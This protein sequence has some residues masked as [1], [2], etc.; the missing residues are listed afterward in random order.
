M[1]ALLLLERTVGNRDSLTNANGT[2]VGYAYDELNRLTSVTNYSPDDSVLS[3]FTYV[4]NNAGIRTVVTEADASTGLSTS[5]SRVNYIYDDCYKLTS[6]TRSGVHPY[7]ISY[8][9]DNIGNRLTRTLS[10]A[11]GGVTTSYV[12]N[13][14]DQLTSEDSAG[15]VTTYTYDAAGRMSVKTF[16]GATT[17]YRFEDND[18]MVEVNGPG[19]A[20]HYV[21]DHNGQRV[22]EVSSA[23]TVNYLIDYQLPYGQVIA[24]MD[25]SGN[26]VATYVYGLDRLSQNR[27]SILSTYQLD[28]QGSIRALTDSNGSLTDTY[29]YT[30]FG[31]ELARTGS[32]VNR[33]RYVGEQWDANAGF[34]YNRARWYSPDQGR[35]TSVDPWSGDP[36]SPVSLHRYLYGNASPLSFKDPS[37][38]FTLAG[39]LIGISGREIM[40]GVYMMAAAASLSLVSKFVKTNERAQ[41]KRSFMR[42]QVQKGIHDHFADQ[43]ITGRNPPGISLA[44]FNAALFEFFFI[45]T[46]AI[47]GRLE[48]DLL[49]AIARTSIW[50]KGVKDAGGIFK[51]GTVHQ[52]YF[53]TGNEDDYR[54]DVENNAGYNLRW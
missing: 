17:T 20:I 43:T 35:F 50:A 1:K 7:S 39:E 19:V 23:D 3:S 51:I 21:Y 41:D 53:P 37:G 16:A 26:L 31:E 15:M 8:T 33:F 4:L 24:E 14:R 32:T 12:Y 34:Y 11:E 27:N 2:A 42:L 13:N 30:A 44:E 10:G 45:A 9:Y 54:L 28:G 48:S 29:W 52:E 6:E 25:G 22:R 36:Q 5:G 46:G 49:G 38:K 40:R 47:P 18:R